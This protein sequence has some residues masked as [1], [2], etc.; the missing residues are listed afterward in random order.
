MTLNNYA[1]SPMRNQQ[2]KRKLLVTWT[3]HESQIFGKRLNF[4]VNTWCRQHSIKNAGT[5][6]G[7]ILL[8]PIVCQTT[9]TRRLLFEYSPTL[10]ANFWVILYWVDFKIRRRTTLE[11]INF[12]EKVL[13]IPARVSLSSPLLYSKDLLSLLYSTCPL[14]DIEA[15]LKMGVAF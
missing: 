11:R 1:N 10:N 4:D 13:F 5:F 2:D 12:S 3:V 8:A 9:F 14:L 6:L 7:P 15:I